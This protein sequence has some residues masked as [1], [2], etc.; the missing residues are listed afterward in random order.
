M[1][2]TTIADV[3]IDVSIW[4]AKK[5]YGLGYW[6]VWGTPKTET[7]I[8]LEKQNK[9]IELLHE[10][11]V[12][13]NEILQKIESEHNNTGSTKLYE[14]LS[15]GHDTYDTHDTA[16]MLLTEEPVEIFKK[17]LPQKFEIIKQNGQ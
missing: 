3:T 11:L 14:S 15:D 17:E 6:L 8:L 13:I 1:V 12:K 10:D 9:T 7:E 4:S 2:L 16:P 5:I